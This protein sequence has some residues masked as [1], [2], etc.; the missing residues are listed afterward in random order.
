[1]LLTPHRGGAV[2][3]FSTLRLLSVSWTWTSPCGVATAIRR[4]L[5]HPKQ[6]NLWLPFVWPLGHTH[7]HPPTHAYTFDAK[8]SAKTPKMTLSLYTQIKSNRFQILVLQSSFLQGQKLH[9]MLTVNRFPF[10]LPSQTVELGL[11]LGLIK[12]RSWV[13]TSAWSRSAQ[14][15]DRVYAAASAWMWTTA[16]VRASLQG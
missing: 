5:I 4:E 7:T 9:V 11:W 3:A 2:C 10:T 14:G 1:M 16:K 8:N 15:P 12:L 13:Q 6:P